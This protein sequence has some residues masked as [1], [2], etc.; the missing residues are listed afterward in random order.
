M[1]RSK[2]Y[3][4]QLALEQAT[5][6]FSQHGYEGTS[7]AMLTSTLGIGKQSL[8]DCF[9][10]KRALLSKCLAQAAGSFKPALHLQRA[11][12]TGRAAIEHFFADLVT[13]C[14]SEEDHG[15]LVSNL[16]LEKGAS[17]PDIQDEAAHYWRQSE[18]ALRASCERGLQDGSI[19]CKHS[20]EV[21]AAMLMT[22]M[23][24]LRVSARSSEMPSSST[25]RVRTNDLT[26]MRTSTE[27]FL[28]GLF[29]E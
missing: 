16:L 3:C 1:P 15:C 7:L 12:L 27:V 4:E 29:S 25:K 24:G 8:Y 10:D 18:Q 9:G 17:D 21:L 19:R 14:L 5:V 23:S 2:L 28:R 6:L 20:A 13:L 26:I 11:R 22:W